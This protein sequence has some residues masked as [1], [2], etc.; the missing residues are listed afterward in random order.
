MAESGAPV[1]MPEWLDKILQEHRDALQRQQDVISTLNA[2]VNSLER[3]NHHADAM[4]EDSLPISKAHAEP[5]RPRPRLPDPEAFTGDRNEWPMWKITIRNKL[6]A[7][8]LALGDAATQFSYVFSRLKGTAMKNVTT[9]V[10]T[11]LAAGQTDPQDLLDYLDKLYGDPNSK[12]RAARKLFSLRQADN[13]PF[14][15]FLPILEREFADAGALDWHDDAKIQVLQRS[16]NKKMQTAL[17]NRD[18]PT[19]MVDTIAL[20][21]KISVNMDSLS[22][23]HQGTPRTNPAAHYELA[24]FPAVD[25]YEPMDWTLSVQVNSTN[26]RTPINPD[27][28]PSTR[29]EDQPLVGKTAK[30]VS[31]EI[32]NKRQEDGRCRRCGRTGCQVRQCPLKAAIPPK[33]DTVVRGRTR[34]THQEV[35]VEV[36]SEESSDD[37]S[38]YQGKA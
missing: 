14:S 19:T 26:I 21:H 15:K 5:H 29:S 8:A 13:Q 7:D 16:L 6:T 12:A 25:E 37:G 9:F 22:L 38:N 1:E 18:V 11:R 28:Y 24:G 35:L 4:S 23:L 2:K 3:Q 34:V 32:L 30:W 31:K 27:G 36:Q 17:F 10:T 20:L 33:R